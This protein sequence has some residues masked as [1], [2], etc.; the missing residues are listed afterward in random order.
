[1]TPQII[2]L[3]AGG[4]Y[5]HLIARRVRG[6]GVSAEIRDLET[7]AEELRGAKG[8]V[9]SGGPSSVYEEDSPTADPGIFDVGIPLLGICYGHQLMAQSLGGNVSRGTLREYGVAELRVQSAADLFAGLKDVEKVWMSH[10]DTVVEPPGGFEVIGATDECPIAAMANAEKRFY[11][12]Q[13]HPEVVH[14]HCGGRILE[15]FISSICHCDIDWDPSAAVDRVIQE[16]RRKAR[17]RHVFFLL[18]GG[19]DSTVAFKLCVMALGHERTLGLYIDTGFMRKHETAR[20]RT[21]FVHL[22]LENARIADESKRFFDALAGV[23]D[24]EEKRIR[25][26]ELFYQL[27]D[28]R[29]EE[30]RKAGAQWMLGQGTIYPD[31]VE[32]GRSRKAAKIKTHHNRVDLMQRLLEENNLL[33]PLAEFYKDEVR[34]IAVRLALPEEIIW[35]HPFPGPGL[36]IRCLCALQWQPIEEDEALTGLVSKRGMWAKLAGLRTV[37][38]QGDSRTYTKLALI[39]G[40][41]TPSTLEEVSTEITN[42]LASVNRVAYV[43]APNLDRRA[44]WRI[45]PGFLTHDRIAL[46]READGIVHEFL[47]RYPDIGRH[48]WQCPVILAPITHGEGESIALRPV[49]SRDGMTAE[50]TKIPI[51]LLREVSQELLQVKG[52]DCVLYDVTNKPP[53]TI[54]WE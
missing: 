33:E 9:I 38:V 8:I 49:S 53:G 19:V 6:L 31:T 12:V 42:A 41:A 13:F 35:R 50:F 1:M 36:A 54:E 16:I 5:C 43:V 40:E 27:Q 29:L 30:L 18:S 48:I 15:N 37:G 25:I 26:G 32:T 10:A 4:Q 7:A 20:M 2:V 11:G 21:M 45:R 23:Y 34:E 44:P 3:N 52:I 28:E 46:L 24:P 14:T 22:G 47:Q 17:D 39:G 51:E